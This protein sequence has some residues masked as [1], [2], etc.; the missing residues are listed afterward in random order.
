MAVAVVGLLSALSTSMSNASRLTDY[1]RASMLARN[2]MDELLTVRRLPKLQVLE[3]RY[4]PAMTGGLESGWRAK[5]TPFELPPTPVSGSSIL[6]RV[7]LEIW[8]LAAGP[9]G[10]RRTFTLETFRRS[11]LTPEDIASGALLVR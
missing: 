3:G 9:S 4:E 6:E 5:V 1:D 8:W 7:E 11:V 10:Q 2:K